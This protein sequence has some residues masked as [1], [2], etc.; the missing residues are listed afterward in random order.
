MADERLAVY[1]HER[2]IGHLIPRRNG[3]RFSFLDEIKASLVGSPML[4]TALIVQD[5]EFDTLQTR[6]WFTGLLPEGPRLTELSRFFGIPEDD[7]LS[8]LREVGWECAG[9][10][11]IM[12]EERTPATMQALDTMLVVSEQ[13]LAQRLEALPSHPYD[14]ARSLRVSLGGFQEKLCICSRMP[15]RIEKGYTN[16]REVGI[17]LDG[18][19]TTHILKPQPE[20]FPGMIEGEAWAMA[21]ASQ[22]TPTAKTAL[23]SIE[24]AP[25][26]LLVERFDRV[27]NG[28]TLRRIHQEDCAQAMGLGPLQKY[29]ASG[30]PKR[31][32]PS[33]LRISSLL[34]T[35]SEDPGEQLKLLLA[36]MIVNVV[37]GN[38]DAHAKNYAFMHPDEATIS[39]AP[40]YDVVPAREITP[41]VTDM[42]MRIGGRIRIDRIGYD[43]LIDEAESWGMPTVT[44]QKVV[45]EVL[46]SFQE[47]IDY[48]NGLYPNAGDRHA[49]ASRARKNSLLL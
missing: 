33:F 49:E 29:A 11:S 8:V 34:K 1:L 4:S 24:G 46:E 3:A 23:L 40:L 35:Y 16:L 21:V 5:D 28:G 6:N 22:V 27:E 15:I 43:Q 25:P 14:E 31:G 48:A 37:A 30:S 42:G 17:P 41:Q 26:T 20:R 38:T 36:Q 2:H 19:P 7:Y 44:A 32:D 10:V 47:G 13:E 45:R 12:A 39:L 9:A 18:A